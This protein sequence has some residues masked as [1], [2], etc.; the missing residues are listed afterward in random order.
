MTSLARILLALTACA[1]ALSLAGCGSGLTD[2]SIPIGGTSG[3]GRLR[4]VVV[5]AE[6]PETPITGARVTLRSPEGMMLRV[7][8]D[9][10]GNFEFENVPDGVQEVTFEGSRPGVL[11]PVRVNVRTEYSSFSTIAV[12]LEPARLS[13]GEF[14]DPV[15]ECN[16]DASRPGQFVGLGIHV[17]YLCRY[18]VI[19]LFPVFLGHPFVQYDSG[20]VARLDIPYVALWDL[21]DDLERAGVHDLRDFLADVDVV[22]FFPGYSVQ[23]AADRGLYLGSLKPGLCGRQQRLAYFVL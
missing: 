18:G 9:E 4:G 7:S 2:G 11:L 17:G 12:A 21:H 8:S 13:V 1:A 20:G 10:Q 6:S 19:T 14:I 3:N 16:L 23:D 22:A 15:L 5:Y